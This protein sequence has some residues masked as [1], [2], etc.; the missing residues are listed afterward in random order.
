MMYKSLLTVCTATLLASCTTMEEV[1][2][3]AVGSGDGGKIRNVIVM[4]G[5]GMGPQQVGLLDSYVRYASD[6]VLDSSAFDRMATEGVVGISRTESNKVLVVDSAASATQFASGKL[7]GSEMIGADFEGNRAESMLEVA[8]AKGKAVGLVSDTRLTHATPAAY[9]AHQ[10]HRSLENEIAAEMLD[11]GADV[12]LSGGIRHWLPQ[13]VN[14]EGSAVRQELEELTGGTISLSSKRKDDRN[15]L[16]EASEAGYDLSFNR[17]DLA[18]STGDRI[19]GLYS[20]SG[21][22]DGIAHTQAGNGA[23]RV[24]PSLTEMTAKALSVLEDDEDGFFLMVEGGQIDWAAHNNDAGTMLHEMIKFSDAIDVVLDWME[25]RDDTLLVVSADHETGGFGFAY[26]RNDLPAGQPLDGDVFHGEEYK[27]NWNFG[28]VET[29]DRLYE[30]KLSYDGIF[31]QFDSLDESQQTPENLR[32]IV[33]A[34]TEFP[35]TLAQARRVLE[36]EL[37]VYYV[38]D[39]GT[40]SAERF[41][42]MHERKAFYVYGSGIR[43]NIL[44]SVVAEQSNVVWASDNHSSTPVYLFAMGPDETTD[45]F[46]GILHTTD[47]ANEIIAVLD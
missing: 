4:I 40:L 2:D 20:S 39:H 38:P 9:A 16:A 32:M 6:P 37:N 26:S 42:L 21:M 35:I 3:K 46:K 17:T 12:M 43:K 11:T 31:S 1:K 18:A 8:Q 27:P 19:L 14:E 29:L 44:A 22:L 47:W 15:L 45:A 30:Q 34:N 36:T 7:A 24:Q 5:D 23:E 41:P 25:G 28:N 33:N 10:Q 13:G